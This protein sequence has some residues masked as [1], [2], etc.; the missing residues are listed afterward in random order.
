[1]IINKDLDNVADYH[2][3][4]KNQLA[5]EQKAR[6]DQE[7]LLGC[8]REND[9]K[10]KEQE[11]WH[12][13]Y[14][15]FNADMDDRLKATL[16]QAK[17]TLDKQKQ[18]DDKINDDFDKYGNKLFD[19]YDKNRQGMDA[20]W[21]NAHNDN[22]RHLKDKTRAAQLTKKK[23]KEDMDLKQREAMAYNQNEE[24]K[25]REMEDQRNL[26]RETL[27]N[28][29]TL[30]A[31]NKHN[32][33]KMTMQ[34][35]HLNKPDLKAYKNKERNT[36]KALIPGIKNIPSVGTKPLMR[37]AMNV[38]D[39]GDSPPEGPLGRR[40]QVFFS[41]EPRQPEGF[42][43]KPSYESPLPHQPAN[44]RNFHATIQRAS[45]PGSMMQSD[46]ISKTDFERYKQNS[47][48][49]GNLRGLNTTRN[50]QS[51]ASMYNPIVHPVDKSYK[52]QR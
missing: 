39:F 26:Y 23:D 18:I 19:D 11:D 2:N 42:L 51:M 13:R 41:P 36:V 34:E 12:N 49:S 47:R 9:K 31:L 52:L 37:G 43:G 16:A 14:K 1:M 30:N 8:Q 10:D 27:Q 6:E 40:G 15:K 17:P 38:M 44:K 20:Q 45:T 4:V 32:F 48:N 22:L 25:K 29:M 7:Y 46:A 33:G 35:K 3:Y 5:A 50:A 24:A 21:R 28:Q